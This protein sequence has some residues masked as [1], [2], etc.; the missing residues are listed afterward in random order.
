MNHQHSFTTSNITHGQTVRVGLGSGVER[1]AQGHFPT[2][3]L[4]HQAT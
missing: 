3:V 4:G 2:L 1:K